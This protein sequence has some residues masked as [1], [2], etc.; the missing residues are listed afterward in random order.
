[1]DART[2][3]RCSRANWA[4]SYQRGSNRKQVPRSATPWRW[5]DGGWRGP[6]RGAADRVRVC[7]PGASFDGSHPKLHCHGQRRI[8]S[9]HPLPCPRSAKVQREND[10][11]NRG[12]SRP[13]L[14]ARPEPAS[15][16]RGGVGPARRVT[17]MRRGARRAQDFLPPFGR[18]RGRR[19]IP[20]P[21]F[22]GVTSHNYLISS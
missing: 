21:L 3:S 7:Q 15:P 1:M 14:R 9:G 8:L 2:G 12:H 22:K 16:P 17:R 5:S 6:G 4:C 10:T 20:E 11:P 18:E 13:G 19:Q